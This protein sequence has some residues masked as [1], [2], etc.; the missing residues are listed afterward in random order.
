MKMIDG[1]KYFDAKAVEGLL[2]DLMEI[3]RINE[4]SKYA[5]FTI[6]VGVSTTCTV[7][8]SGPV[9]EDEFDSLLS[10]IVY[11]KRYVTEKNDGVEDRFQQAMRLIKRLAEDRSTEEGEG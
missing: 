7:S 4:T 11:Y 3:I 10:H 9:T 5:N 2:S 6:P 1:K 8:F